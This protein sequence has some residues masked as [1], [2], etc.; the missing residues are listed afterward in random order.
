MQKTSSV[1]FVKQVKQEAKKIT[2]PKR[3]EIVVTGIMVLVMVF[4][5]AIFFLLVDS[6]ASL[7]VRKIL[8]LGAI[9]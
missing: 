5:A 1:E 9:L 7:I 8:S 2:W 3:K 6:S 4:I